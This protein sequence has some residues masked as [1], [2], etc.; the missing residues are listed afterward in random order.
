MLLVHKGFRY[1]QESSSFVYGSLCFVDK[2]T[3]GFAVFTIQELT[4]TAC[5]GPDCSD[6]FRHVMSLG[7]FVPLFLCFIAMCLI[8]RERIGHTRKLK[9]A[10]QD[11]DE[12][13][14]SNSSDSSEILLS[15]TTNLGY[16][17]VT[18]V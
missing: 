4:R 15:T 8:S 14:S 5:L 6:Y 1:F 2:I 9:Q 3:N 13:L 10:Y 18:K 16:G 7:I 11:R 12:S 17:T